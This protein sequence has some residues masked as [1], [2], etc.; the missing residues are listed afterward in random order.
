MIRLTQNMEL[1]RGMS[2][3]QKYRDVIL[4]KGGTRDEMEMFVEF[5]GRPPEVEP[6]IERRG[7][8]SR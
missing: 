1:G 4:S 2:F 6:L 8:N 7:L 3:A 5:R